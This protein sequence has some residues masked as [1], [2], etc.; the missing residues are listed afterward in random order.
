MA[1]G[2]QGKGDGVMLDIKGLSVGYEDILI[3]S[4]DFQ[5]KR[6]EIVTLIGPNGAGKSTILKTI[7]RHLP[8]KAGVVMIDG[9]QWD[10]LSAAELAKKLAVVLTDR[11]HPELMTCG[12]LVAMGRYPYTNH[13]GRLTPED[14]REVD[15]A[16]EMV[17]AL[18]L[19]DVGF[20]RLSDGQ[21]Q[22][23]LLARAICQKPDVLVLDE[24][25]SYLDVR[26]KLELLMILQRLARDEKITVI[27]SLH[28]IDLAA[29]V[30]DKI[31]CVNRGELQWFG[32]PEEMFQKDRIRQLYSIGDGDYDPLYGSVELGRPGG[33]ARLLVVGGA[34]SGIMWYRRL[35]RA[36][37]PFVA[38]VLYENDLDYPVAE[39]LAERVVSQKPFVP[40]EPMRDEIYGVLGRMDMVLDCGCEHGEYDSLNQDVLKMAAEQGKLQTWERIAGRLHA[41]T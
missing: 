7:S 31:L 36:N 18:D 15:D 29:K 1:H 19:K 12:D 32:T 26:H 33:S 8:A 34:G 2:A 14:R 17:H 11:I 10:R 3:D 21:K 25:T 30:S 13:F 37:I 24:P 23:V 4:L 5:V 39:M 41:G 28:E 16:L 9:R 38:G 20:N 40:M 6:G 35:Q 22:R 27:M